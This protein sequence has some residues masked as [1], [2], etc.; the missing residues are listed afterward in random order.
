MVVRPT[1]FLGDNFLWS[2]P[3]VHLISASMS[4]LLQQQSLYDA[5]QVAWIFGCL[6]PG[7]TWK[8]HCSL[9][10]STQF[11]HGNVAW[12]DKLLSYLA[13][14]MTFTSNVNYFSWV[15]M[16]LWQLESRAWS[17]CSWL[18]LSGL[19]AQLW[20]LLCP[21]VMCTE[22]KVIGKISMI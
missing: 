11:I 3:V 22:R 14:T 12:Q 5:L 13:F 20:F 18:V 4:L 10:F 6:L 7:S 19:N 8:D 9:C 16:Q 15:V 1:G 17:L 21:V 2:S